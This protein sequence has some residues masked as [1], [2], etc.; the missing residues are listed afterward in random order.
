[1]PKEASPAPRQEA[2]FDEESVKE[3]LVD[4]DEMSVSSLGSAQAEDLFVEKDDMDGWT[5][6]IQEVASISS[7]DQEKQKQN[8]KND[9]QKI[10]AHESN[11]FI[12][13]TISD[14]NLS[15]ESDWGN[16]RTGY[17]QDGSAKMYWQRNASYYPRKR[18]LARLKDYGT[19]SGGRARS[20]QA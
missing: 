9:T 7:K 3:S 10:N 6:T 8:Q 5:V 11:N 15:Q 20:S 17:S 13:R 2:Y 18:K 12:G 19:A 14:E 4:S 16:S 1:M